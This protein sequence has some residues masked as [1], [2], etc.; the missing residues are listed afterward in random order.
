MT[1]RSVFHGQYFKTVDSGYRLSIQTAWKKKL[2]YMERVS[3]EN[4]RAHR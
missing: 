1:M 2:V 4:I 3:E